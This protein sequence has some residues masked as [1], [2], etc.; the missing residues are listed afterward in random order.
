MLKRTTPLAVAIGIAWGSTAQAEAVGPPYDFCA[1][2]GV[3]SCSYG[4]VTAVYTA[5]VP[6]FFYTQPASAYDPSNPPARYEVPLGFNAVVI[7]Q[8]L[9][10]HYDNGISQWFLDQRLGGLVPATSKFSF[11]PEQFPGYRANVGTISTWIS[12]ETRLINFVDDQYDLSLGRNVKRSVLPDIPTFRPDAG[13]VRASVDARGLELFE[14]SPAF[15]GKFVDFA[16]QPAAFDFV[17]L[18]KGDGDWLD[19][20]LNDKLLWSSLG[21]SFEVGTLYT[22]NFDL[23]QSGTT[24]GYLSLM[25]NSA[26]E[27]NARVFLPTSESPHAAAVPEPATWAMMI[28]G[29][30][31][32]G[33]SMRRKQRQTVGYSFG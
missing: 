6:G 21:Q 20:Y 13:G 7:Q 10:V 12:S 25:L 30:G 32:I 4:A 29:F 31:M 1:Q 11:T 28:A 33:F 15:L 5:Q 2:V 19:V 3:H 27:K 9:T 23:P 18:D 17:F 22:A 8:P 16:S 14:A 26:G 24:S